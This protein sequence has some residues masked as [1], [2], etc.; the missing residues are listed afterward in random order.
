MSSVLTL[1]NSAI[2]AGV[3]SLPYAFRLS[4]ALG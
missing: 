4:G 2:G 1:C 3:L